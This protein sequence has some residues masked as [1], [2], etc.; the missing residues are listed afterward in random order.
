[1]KSKLKM[2][3]MTQKDVEKCDNPNCTCE[4]CNCG[5]YCTCENCGK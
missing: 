5:S 2:G 4:N 1:M 3:G